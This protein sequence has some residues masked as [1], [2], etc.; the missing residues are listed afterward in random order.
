MA[1]FHEKAVIRFCEIAHKSA[2]NA[3]KGS[4]HTPAI[5]AKSRRTRNV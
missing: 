5:R 4:I 1:S 3:I 2:Q